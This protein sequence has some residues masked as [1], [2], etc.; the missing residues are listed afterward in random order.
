MQSGRSCPRC[1]S[2]RTG[3]SRS[4]QDSHMTLEWWPHG[5]LKYQAS[6][7]FVEEALVL[8]SQRPRWSAFAYKVA[9][10]S[11]LGV[12]S[13]SKRDARSTVINAKFDSC[14]VMLK[15]LPQHREV[16]EG[17]VFRA[18]YR[19]LTWLRCFDL[20]VTAA[21]EQGK[22]RNLQGCCSLYA[23]SERRFVCRKACIEIVRRCHSKP[24]GDE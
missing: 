1:S 17:A 8:Q 23:C 13:L 10:M 12:M 21:A 15:N 11:R 19:R 14:K 20:A 4:A 7:I 9:K 5:H 16:F 24:V 22:Q 3:R 18:G 2:H 6:H